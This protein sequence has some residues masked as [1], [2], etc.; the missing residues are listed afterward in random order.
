M[1]VPAC[2]TITPNQREAHQHIVILVLSSLI[3]NH[4]EKHRSLSVL[5][6]GAER[7]DDENA[8]QHGSPAL[9]WGS[10]TLNTTGRHGHLLKSTCDMSPIDM[11]KVY[12]HEMGDLSKSTFTLG[13]FKIN[14]KIAKLMTG[15]MSISRNPHA[16][17]RPP[18]EGPY[19]RS[20][21]RTTWRP[22]NPK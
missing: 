22:G 13:D 17:W 7:P 5:G 6:S 1:L 4:L 14:M 12:S 11:R 21:G 2:L 16:T 15:D 9:H 19:T 20:E 3:V 10:G 18:I 8:L